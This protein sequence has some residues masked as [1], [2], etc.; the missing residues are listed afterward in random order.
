MCLLVAAVVFSF[1]FPGDHFD[2]TSVYITAKLCKG[3]YERDLSVE[4]FSLTALLALHLHPSLR[5]CLQ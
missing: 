3:I 2:H 4:I 1:F 5:C